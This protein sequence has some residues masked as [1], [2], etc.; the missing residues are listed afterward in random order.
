MTQMSV[1]VVFQINLQH[2][3]Y[4]AIKVTKTIEIISIH[5]SAVNRSIACWFV[6]FVNLEN[7]CMKYLFQK[8]DFIIILKHVKV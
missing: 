2:K 4:I 1:G 7:I 8:A 3:S 5:F 6:K